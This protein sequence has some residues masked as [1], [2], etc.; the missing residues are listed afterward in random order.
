MAYYV[1]GG[2]LFYGICLM[3]LGVDGTVVCNRI[4]LVPISSNFRDG[5]FGGLLQLLDEIGHDIHKDN[6]QH[7]RLATL[8]LSRLQSRLPRIQIDATSLPRIHG[9]CSLHRSELL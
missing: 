2:N 5:V 1:C 9:Q 4:D 8:L 7:S 3:G 6:L